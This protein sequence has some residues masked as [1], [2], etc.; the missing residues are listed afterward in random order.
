MEIR[1]IAGYTPYNKLAQLIISDKD[2]RKVL[3]IGTKIVMRLRKE[4]EDDIII[5]GPVLPKIARINNFYRAQIIIK[6]QTSNVIDDVLRNIYHDYNTELS[7]AIDKN[8][9]LL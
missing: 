7:I 5:L 1:K 9:T 3:K 4:L 6:Y 8:P 2:V